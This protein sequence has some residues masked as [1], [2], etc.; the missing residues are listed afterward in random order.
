MFLN[1]VGIS[2]V[3]GVVSVINRSQKNVTVVMESFIVEM[4]FL[5][6]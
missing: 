6:K 4:I 3:Y 5:G 2:R 1:E